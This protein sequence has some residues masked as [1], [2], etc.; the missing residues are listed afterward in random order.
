MCR[1]WR[2]LISHRKPVE[3][4]ER[5]FH[6]PH[7]QKGATKEQQESR[8]RNLKFSE[9]ENE[10]LVERI[11]P[12]FH[13]IIGKYP[14]DSH[15][16]VGK[17]RCNDINTSVI[18]I[19]VIQCFLKQI[20]PYHHLAKADAD[21]RHLLPFQV[22]TDAPL[23]HSPQCDPAIVVD[24]SS[25]VALFSNEEP[26]HIPQQQVTPLART[27]TANVPPKE[28]EKD[29]FHRSLRRH[30]KSLMKKLDTLHVDLCVATNAYNVSQAR[31]AVH[32][33]A[34]LSLQEERLQVQREKVALLAKQNSLLEK[35]IALHEKTPKGNSANML[36][37]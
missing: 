32:E 2:A 6:P 19:N 3:R 10:A 13:K 17:G 16:N 35:Q 27:S 18:T 5:S 20:H 37:H 14:F 25:N 12:V 1:M 9:F 23:L 21:N 31:Q 22:V 24:V 30:N 33:A 26:A 28:P 7:H 11:M 8:L 36:Y 15:R 4:K 29:R 34:M